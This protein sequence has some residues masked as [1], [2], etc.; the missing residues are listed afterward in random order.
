MDF[1]ANLVEEVVVLDSGNITY[2]G[3]MEGMRRDA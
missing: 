3:D 2:R 1:L